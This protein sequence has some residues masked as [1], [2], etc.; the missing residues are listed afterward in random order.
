MQMQQVAY[1]RYPRGKREGGRK[2]EEEAYGGLLKERGRLSGSSSVF[3]R[4]ENLT[5]WCWCHKTHKD[6][7]TQDPGTIPII[8][9]LQYR[10]Q[11]PDH[12]IP[13]SIARHS[14]TSILIV[15]QH[16]RDS[17][18]VPRAN[19]QLV[20]P[21]PAPLFVVAKLLHSSPHHHRH[22]TDRIFTRRPP[23]P[24]LFMLDPRPATERR[25]VASHICISPTTTAEE[26]M[27]ESAAW[28]WKIKAT[29]TLIDRLG[30]G[31]KTYAIAIRQP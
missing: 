6:G 11:E 4:D 24:P 19:R 8:D 25:K 21:C 17:L 2:E 14:L 9:A 23:R 12:P 16:S 20:V 10:G 28:P 30:I 27:R 3:I 7:W 31:T 15:T 1:V 22:R 13:P 26:S 5:K 18:R 29:P